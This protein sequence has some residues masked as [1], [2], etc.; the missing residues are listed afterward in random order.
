MILIP[1]VV[2]IFAVLA[3]LFYLFWTLTFK[4]NHH[5]GAPA[6]AY[7]HVEKCLGFPA[8]K[9]TERQF[10]AQMRSLKDRGFR[11]LTPGEFLDLNGKKSEKA[12]LITFDDTYDSVFEHALPF[13]HSLEYTATLFIISDYIGRPN[14]WDVS[15]SE[16]RHMSAEHIEKAIRDGFNIGSHTRTHPDLTSL[17]DRALEGELSGSKKALEDRFGRPVKYLAYPFGRYNARVKEAARA[18]GYGAA[19]TINRPMFQRAF[20]PFAIPVCGVYGLDTIHDFQAKIDRNGHVWIEDVKD[21]IINR[22]AS[23][24]ALV[25]GGRPK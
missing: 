13:L 6:L 8:T 25:K 2:L 14:R 18:A 3:V 20:D 1:T 24:A 16:N 12:V 11:A 21:K 10:E 17:S 9:I 22:F 5:F 4:R 7:H 15:L 19:F 23:G